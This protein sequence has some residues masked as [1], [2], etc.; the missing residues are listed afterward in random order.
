MRIERIT[1]DRIVNPVASFAQGIKTGPYLFLSAQAGVLPD[2][3]QLVGSC[4]ELPDEEGR[5][6]ATGRLAA[7][8]WSGPV[9]AQCWQMFN[10]IDAILKEHDATLNDILRINMWLTNFRDLPTLMPIRSRPFAP[11]DPPP[12]TNIGAPEL[13]LPGAKIQA[14][15]VV[16]LPEAGIERVVMGSPR[17][18]QSVGDYVLATQGGNLGWPAGM[19]AARNDTGQVVRG[20]ADLGDEAPLLS[21]G[22]LVRNEIEGA[23]AAQTYF[24]LRDLEMTLG[25]NGLTLDD[26]A[27]LTVYIKDIREWPPCEVV[28]SR[29]FGDT[30]PPLT[31]VGCS[32][33]GMDDFRLEIEATFVVAGSCERRFMDSMAQP[34][35]GAATTAVTNDFIFVSGQFGIGRGH[36]DVVSSYEDLDEANDVDLPT[37]SLA[38]DLRDSPAAVQTLV[39]LRNLSRALNDAGSSLEQLV[40]VNVY[41]TQARDIPIVERMF[42]RVFGSDAPAGGMVQVPHLP[43]KEAR[44]EIDG[45]ALRA[46]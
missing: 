25:D 16:L 21:V 13:S 33:L 22:G 27:K 40:K 26:V 41:V 8:S 39:A 30:S 38:T 42:I 23:A 29:F 34:I 35:R 37:G 18:S 6:L 46:R 3:R 17:V 19:I 2:S 28:I 11:Q 5:S 4:A 31:V 1:S 12:I 43:L 36:G 15:V 7:D 45:I 20:T 44:V 9:Q 10:N 24:I 14:E 32:E